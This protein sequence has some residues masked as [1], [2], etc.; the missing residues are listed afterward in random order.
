MERLTIKQHK[1]MTEEYD[2]VK[3]ECSCGPRVIIP[4]WE[5]KQLCH[6]CGKYVY[7]NKKEE[8]ISRVGAKLYGRDIKRLYGRDK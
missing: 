6:W 5:D 8:F 1:H 3:F 4:K 2:K 7:R